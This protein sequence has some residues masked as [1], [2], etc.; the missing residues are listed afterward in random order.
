MES[1]ILELEIRNIY[2]IKKLFVWVVFLGA[3]QW[4]M[5]Q[6]GEIRGKI[7]EKATGE[8]MVGANIVIESITMGT[9][10]DLDGNYSMKVTP[11]TYTVKVSFVSYN[12]VEVTDV[13]VEAGKTAE[14]NIAMEEASTGI[15]EVVVTAVRKMNSEVS[16][17]NALKT[18][19]L[20][21]SGV[22]SQQISKTQDR[23]A[24]EV[25]KRIPGISII[26][27]KFI[28]A[29][30]LSQRYNNVWINNNAVPSSEADSRAFSFDMIPS[31]QIENIMIVKSPAPELPAD[32][33]GGFVKV[34]TKNMPSENT[35]QISY[36][37]HFNSETHFQD[38]KYA[39][40]SGSDFLGFDNGYRDMRSVVPAQRME[41]DA[42]TNADQITQVTRDGFNNDWIV[43]TRRP[44]PDQR[45]SMMLNRYHKMGSGQLGLVAAL[46][47]SYSSRTYADMQNSRYGVY[48][49]RDDQ[50]EY[51]YKYTD[52]Q[53]TTTAKIGGMFNV[54]WMPNDNHRLEFRNILNQSGRDRYTERD[55]YE[56]KSSYYGQQKDEYLYT[57]RTAYTGQ[58]SG[59]HT[60][61]VANKLDWTVGYSYANKNQPDRRIINKQEET[62]SAKYNGL[63]AVEYNGITRD[64][65]RLDENMYSAGINFSHN[66]G[67]GTFTPALKAGVYAEY[68]DRAYDTR[69]FLYRYKSSNLP[70]DFEYCDVPTQ[71]MVSENFAA[72][73][74]YLYDTS[75]KTNNYKGDDLLASGYVGIN[76]PLK[77]LNVYAGV[78]YENNNMGLTNYT[79]LTTDV[80]ETKKY[81]QT[82]FFPSVNATY[83]L[84]KTNLVRFAY[85]QSINRQ[86]FREISPSSYYDFDLFSFVQG[87]PDLK[88]AY[89][90]NFDL[91]YE[92]YPSS[93]ELISLALFY[94]K[95]TN[96]IEW[97]FID[98]GGSYTYTYENAKSAQNYGIELDLKKNLDF[99]GLPALSVTI[100]GAIIDSKVA[101]GEESREHD[102]PMQGQSPYLVN[103]GLFYQNNKQALT[104]GM[105]YNIIGKRIV[106]I[107]KVDTSQGGSIDNDIPDMYEMPRNTIDLSVSYKFGKRWE[108]NAGVRDILAQSVVFK[109]FPQFYD[110][111]GVLQKREQTTKEFKPGR[112]FSASLKL[113]L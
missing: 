37:V 71:I 32:F 11:G 61:S 12:S 72:D 5:A 33:T 95:F 110:E 27:D 62:S 9:T 2:M 47:Y 56:N 57:S 107:G 7:I 45:L 69:Y 43:H 18:S 109:Q 73:K 14:A 52:N 84:N 8:P 30:G 86:E 42:T 4:A 83:N 44:I 16:M 75:D 31:G 60:L 24:S 13:K 108:I 64:F 63:M 19:N 111:S 39:K 112:N 106:G 90:Q 58:L 70:D 51:L 98:A 46:N 81:Q 87:N 66:F 3:T 40:G 100:N 55:G 76:I 65:I 68:R 105:M 93:G 1:E 80:T 29:R 48:N 96:P 25:V 35:F 49:S 36:G 23:D 91:R 20:V 99:I 85:G 6:T 22:S 41:N 113:N 26:D 103:A 89:I 102:R 28:V 94:K 79:T 101:F 82:D 10:A 77:N 97:T 34:A 17:I 67:F 53:Y 54:I 88:P 104:V 21:L 74:L 50:P 59:T 38:F 92:I 15:E 78:R